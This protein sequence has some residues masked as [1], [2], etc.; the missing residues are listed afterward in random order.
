MN[1]RSQKK[2]AS[3]ILGSGMSRVKIDTARLEDVDAAIT[4]EE[5]RKL[6]HEGAIRIV[7]K[8]GV[9]RGRIRI[10]QA[11]KKKGR[12]KGAGTRRGKAG[13]RSPKKTS[14]I[15]DVRAVRRRLRALR[16]RKE[17]PDHAYRHLY[18]MIKGGTFRSVS[19][20]EQYLEAQSLR[21]R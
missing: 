4:R 19:R 5:I 13:A 7:Q 15:R 2:L 10:I 11:Q 20:L 8:K 16:D 12:R 6:A 1:L 9:S 21:R 17:L 3:E 14:W 18:L